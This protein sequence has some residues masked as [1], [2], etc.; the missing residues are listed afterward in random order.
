MKTVFRLLKI[1][2]LFVDIYKAFY[3]LK[4]LIRDDKNIIKYNI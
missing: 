1:V 2:F 3:I 4:I